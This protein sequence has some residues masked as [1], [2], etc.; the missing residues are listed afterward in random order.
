VD[1]VAE[2]QRH[3]PR[4]EVL[5]ACDRC[6]K[7]VSAA[8]SV[9]GRAWYLSDVPVGGGIT[10][11]GQLRGGTHPGGRT[12][13]DPPWR[14]RLWDVSEVGRRSFDPETAGEKPRRDS[15]RRGN[16][17]FVVVCDRRHRNARRQA[18][19]HQQVVTIV[20]LNRVCEE[21][22]TRSGSATARITLADLR[23]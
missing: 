19:P 21:A 4:R 12:R 1:L 7:P 8:I 13:V 6:G 16:E 18:R 10:P 14:A 2:W 5:I 22:V 17:R 15:M 11:Q 20:T 23:R 3:L 9:E